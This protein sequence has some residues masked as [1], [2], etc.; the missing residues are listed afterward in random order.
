M[1]EPKQTGRPSPPGREKPDFFGIYHERM[2][3]TSP[4]RVDN[5]VRNRWV[6][7]IK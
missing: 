6:Q 5:I 4:E 3:A 7:F 1:A 2:G